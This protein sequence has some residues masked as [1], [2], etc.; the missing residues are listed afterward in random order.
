MVVVIHDPNS[1]S[2]SCRPGRWGHRT[3]FSRACRVRRLSFGSVHVWPSYCRN[4][5]VCGISCQAKISTDRT[6]RKTGHVQCSSAMWQ[7]LYCQN[8]TGLP[9]PAESFENALPSECSLLPG[10]LQCQL[11]REEILSLCRPLCRVSGTNLVS[12]GLFLVCPESFRV[13]A[14]PF[15]SSPLALNSMHGQFW[16]LVFIFLCEPG[17]LAISSLSSR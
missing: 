1:S 9:S 10:R 16:L 5:E 11:S 12:G 4:R 7:L 8:G 2:H 17:Y 6:L 14:P 3:G 13:L 15:L